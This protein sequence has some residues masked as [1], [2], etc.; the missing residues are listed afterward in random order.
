MTEETF[1]FVRIER[2][3]LEIIENRDENPGAA[4]R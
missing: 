4:G 3:Y 2:C 1:Y